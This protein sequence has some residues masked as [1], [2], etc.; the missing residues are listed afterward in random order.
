MASVSFILSRKTNL[1]ISVI[2]SSSVNSYF[3]ISKLLAGIGLTDLVLNICL[4][5]VVN[6]HY[7][8]KCCC[9]LGVL[10]Y[11]IL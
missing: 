5:F 6:E 7:D 4:H 8:V 11:N 9:P 2:Y 1:S 10:W 3:K